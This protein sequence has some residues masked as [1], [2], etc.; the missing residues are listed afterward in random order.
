MLL[1][2]FRKKDGILTKRRLILFVSC[3]AKIF[4]AEIGNPHVQ[5]GVLKQKQGVFRRIHLISVCMFN[6]LGYVG[7]CSVMN[8]A[9]SLCKTSHPLKVHKNE[10]FFGFDF[11]FCTISFLVMHK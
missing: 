10:N 1:Y 6:V 3:S 8:T 4:W 7:A 5:E 2:L 11:E 9:A